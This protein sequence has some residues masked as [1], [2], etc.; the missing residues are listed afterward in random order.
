M[1]NRN[2]SAKVHVHATFTIS[3]PMPMFIAGVEVLE[4]KIE[5]GMFVNIPLNRSLSVTVRVLATAPV[6]ND[7]GVELLGLVLNCD[8]DEEYREFIDC[9]NVGDEI[10]DVTLEG[11]D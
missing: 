6:T 9:L 4:G 2:V 8:N 10:W 5:P 1:C 7:F 3:Q 11:E